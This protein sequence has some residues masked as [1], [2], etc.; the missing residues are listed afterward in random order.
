M[1]LYMADVAKI[2]KQWEGGILLDYLGGPKVI[3]Q[4]LKHR[5]SYLH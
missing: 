4:V 2:K 1:L 3:T 5:E